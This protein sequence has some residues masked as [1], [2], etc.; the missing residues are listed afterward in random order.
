[1]SLFNNVKSN[2]NRSSIA[3]IANAAI[4]KASPKLKVPYGLGNAVGSMINGRNPADGI[5]SAGLGMLQN[6][7]GAKIGGRLAQELFNLFG[8][9]GA[10]LDVP[11]EIVGGISLKDAKQIFDR[12][13]QISY[14]RKNL[15]FV[16]IVD[17]M[18]GDQN[19]LETSMM[20]YLNL[21]ATEVSYAPIT[22][23]GDPISIG[24]A[25]FD[26]LKAA[27]RIEFRVTTLDDSQGTIK[28]WFESKSA[29]VAHADGTFGRPSDYLLKLNIIHA[30]IGDDVSG[31]DAAF[32]REYIVRPGSIEL[33][34]SRREDGL[35]ELQMSFVQHDTFSTIR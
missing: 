31:A 28:R 1:M 23:Q 27:E 33:D 8:P 16:S 19:P 34:L 9:A 2:V 3:R 5:I 12:T 35:E 18:M 30:V 20:A 29:N 17:V 25:V 6:R 10:S 32:N 24:S 13:S 14:A 15:F 4:T 11:S 21:F 7:L 26:S 22:I